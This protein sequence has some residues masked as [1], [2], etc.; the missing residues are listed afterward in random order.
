M[1][2]IHIERV[3]FV[4]FL[5]GKDEIMVNTI[6]SGSPTPLPTAVARPVGDTVQPAAVPEKSPTVADKPVIQ[7]PKRAEVKLDAETM[8]KNLQEAIARINDMMRDGGRGLQFSIDEKLGG[9]VILVKNEDSGEVI[10]QIPNEAVVKV[11]HSIEDL[12]GMLHNQTV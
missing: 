5:P 10:R 12:K 6:Q 2:T 11:A 9:P 4:F 1:P 7:S 8:R 3:G